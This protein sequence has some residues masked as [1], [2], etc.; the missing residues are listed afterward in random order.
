VAI[1]YSWQKVLCWSWNSIPISYL[2]CLSKDWI[3]WKKHICSLLTILTIGSL[4]P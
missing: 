1:L 4:V 3:Q 2:V